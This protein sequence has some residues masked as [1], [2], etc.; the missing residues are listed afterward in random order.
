MPKG[1]RV[2]Q[3]EVSIGEIEQIV[4]MTENGRFRTEIAKALN[5]STHTIWRYQKQFCE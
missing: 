3:I 1:R 5:R 2:G 4:E